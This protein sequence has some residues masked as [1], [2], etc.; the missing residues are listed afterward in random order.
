MAQEIQVADLRLGKRTFQ[1]KNV[2]VAVAVSGL[3]TLMELTPVADLVRVFFQIDVAD[4]A[5]DAFQ[6]QGK[7]H[8][9]GAYQA[10]YSAAADFTTPEG[11]LVGASGDLT[12]QGAGTTGW[13]V[14]EVRGLKALRVQAS[15]NTGI[16]TVTA[17]ACGG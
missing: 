9:D 8:E 1:S 2:D 13:F 10:L 16:S 17:F 14:L 15:A 6:I 12:T 3:T 7:F 11:L 4:N 5:L